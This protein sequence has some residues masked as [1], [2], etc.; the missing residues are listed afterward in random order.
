MRLSRRV[1]GGFVF[2]LGCLWLLGG[3]AAYFQGHLRPALILVFC[4]MALARMGGN[5]LKP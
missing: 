5:M 3:I 4:G 2:G 1:W